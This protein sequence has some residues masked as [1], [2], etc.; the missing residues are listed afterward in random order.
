MF[1]DCDLHCIMQIEI[2]MSV[3]PKVADYDRLDELPLVTR[4]SP[5]GPR[6]WLAI[7]IF[8]VLASA[9][10]VLSVFL[11]VHATLTAAKDT[12]AR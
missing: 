2:E 4:D 9:V 8:V 12:R 10:A 1:T 5:N 3:L 11:V 6:R 7:T